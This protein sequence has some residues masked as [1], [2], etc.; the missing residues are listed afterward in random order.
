MQK[1]LVIGGL[2]VL[3]GL[4]EIGGLPDPGWLR[5]NKPSRGRSSGPQPWSSTT[6]SPP[7][8]PLPSVAST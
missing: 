3:A 4:C 6:W 2:F 5:Q 8:S 1:L 7:C